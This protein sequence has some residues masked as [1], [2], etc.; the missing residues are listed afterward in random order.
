[1]S[2][3]EGNVLGLFAGGEGLA[4]TPQAALRVDRGGAQGDRHHGRDANRALLLVPEA[5]YRAIR[6]EGIDLP[7]GSLG[8][9][10]V[11]S[12]IPSGLHPGTRLQIGAGEVEV[13]GDCTVCASLSAIDPRLPK[14]A[15]RR[16]GVYVRVRVEGR[17]NVG[18]EVRIVPEGVGVTPRIQLAA[19]SHQATALGPG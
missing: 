16:R 13:T 6:A 4:K 11:V 15:Y 9:N 5:D 17:L 19:G 12:A 14:L 10:L 3:L 18:D 1:M 7:L 2:V 8:E